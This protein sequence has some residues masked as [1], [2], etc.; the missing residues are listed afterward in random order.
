[1]TT[2]TSVSPR[3]PS[4]RP[5]L[6][7]QTVIL[8]GAAGNIGNVMTRQ[9]L[10]EGA[11]VVVTGRNEEKLQ[12]FVRQL[13]S[14]GFDEAGILPVVADS[15]DPEACRR[16]VEKTT[17]HFGKLDV[18]V[19]NAGGSGPKR[20]L[21]NIPFT[22]ADCMAQN[23]WETMLDS[24][25]NLLG[26]PWN[27]V[28]AAAP[29]M[30]PGGSIVNVSTIFSRT[31]YFGRI[32]YVVP[33]SGL[34]ALS[35]GLAR[36]LGRE[37]RG[38]RVNTVFPG[39]IES[40]RIDKVFDAMDTL[41]RSPR[42]STSK[43]FKDLMILERLGQDELPEIRYPTPA[44]VSS[45]T[46]WLAS[47]EA[48][49]FSGHSFEVTNGMQVPAQSR[50]K[51]V[52]WPDLRLVDLRDRV[53]LI[54]GGRDTEEALAFTD[55]H[56]AHGAHVVLAFRS[57]HAL[58]QARSRIQNRSSRPIPLLLLDP[59]K[60]ETIE[61]SMQFVA[62]QHGRLDAVVVLPAGPNGGF[63]LATASDED[64]DRYLHDEIVAPVAF[65]SAVAKLLRRWQDL[66][67][68]PA[69]TYVTNPDDGRGNRLNDVARASIEQLIRVWREE[70]EHDVGNGERKW[71]CMPNQLVRFNNSE[72]ENLLFSADWAVTLANRVRKMDP[73]NLWVPRQVRRATGRAVE[74]RS[75]SRPSPDLR[76]SVEG[77]AGPGEVAAEMRE[78]D[79]PLLRA[80]RARRRRCGHAGP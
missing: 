13:V 57:L 71:S 18:L 29:R 51:L 80:S 5:R 28:R 63:D 48:A 45:I 27:M 22:E 21:E 58:E 8:T 50:S 4:T 47:P 76:S 10:L 60:R 65:A 74:R 37:G 14:E 40:E 67:Q 41:Q 53:V 77:E 24:T 17:K 33:K 56:L 34:N 55:R 31:P 72:P 46:T 16:L 73:I 62:D 15:S 64:V 75:R 2:E 3:P 59:S 19:N 11:Q 7:N 38:I 78:E 12:G 69:I 39:P 25:K 54:L 20:T 32:P 68:A 35:L 70:E 6:R 9:L 66:K 44:D 49:A 26:G 52:S 42:G 43:R 23:E 61:R 79:A 36:E 30:R 1:M